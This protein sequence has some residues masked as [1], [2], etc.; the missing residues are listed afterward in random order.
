MHYLSH[1]LHILVGKSSLIHHLRAHCP[2]HGLLPIILVLEHNAELAPLIK[3]LGAQLCDVVPVLELAVITE[4]ILAVNE[5]LR[6]IVTRVFDAI[7]LPSYGLEVNGTRGVPGVLCGEG[8]DGEDGNG[9]YGN[10]VRGDGL[11][12]VG[13]N[14]AADG[15]RVCCDRVYCDG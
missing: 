4:I 8:A 14:Y 6:V 12:A 13:R 15:D 10:G 9:M 1:S 7:Q 11:M 3:S 2:N 5:P